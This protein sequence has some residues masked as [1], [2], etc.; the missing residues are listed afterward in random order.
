MSKAPKTKSKPTD[1]ALLRDARAMLLC[2]ERDTAS[3][4]VASEL[5]KPLDKRMADFNRLHPH[6]GSAMSQTDYAKKEAIRSHWL[7]TGQGLKWT[8]A[9]SEFQRAADASSKACTRVIRH[10]P[11]SLAGAAY[12]ALAVLERDCS[13]GPG[14]GYEQECGVRI[15]L[16]LFQAAGLRLPPAVRRLVK[17]APDTAVMLR[18]YSC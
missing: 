8:A 7:T 13:G 9:W 2:L 12:I 14:Y 4:L 17:L 3:Y 5:K 15:M 10:K 11:K 1:V 16:A 6:A 18:R